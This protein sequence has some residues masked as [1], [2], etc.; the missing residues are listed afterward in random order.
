MAEYRNYIFEISP[1]EKNYDPDDEYLVW[2]SIIVHKGDNGEPY[3][4][5]FKNDEKTVSYQV[6]PV[7][8]KQYYAQAIKIYNE[9]INKIALKTFKGPEFEKYELAQEILNSTARTNEHKFYRI[10]H[11]SE[12]GIYTDSK[13]FSQPEMKNIEVSFIDTKLNKLSLSQLAIADFETGVIEHLNVGHHIYLP[14]GSL[15]NK[16]I[17]AITT[18]N[19]LAYLTPHELKKLVQDNNNVM[20]KLNVTDLK[21]N[22]YEKLKYMFGDKGI[23]I[24]LSFISKKKK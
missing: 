5:T 9:K 13:L 2:K 6:V 21:T 10:F 23:A 17:L 15:S 12:P 20:L 22:N 4:V 1:E 7:F 24:L 11:V 8:S 16:A 19:Q 18:N 14:L 3:M